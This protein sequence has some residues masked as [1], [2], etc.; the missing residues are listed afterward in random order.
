MKSLSQRAVEKERKFEEL[1]IDA[2]RRRERQDE[3][4]AWQEAQHSFQPDIGLTKHRQLSDKTPRDFYERLHRSGRAK[5]DRLARL[6]NRTSTHDPTTG[7]RLF[8][9]K[10]GRAP[11]FDR[12]AS[13]LSVHEFLF[14]S[15]HEYDDKRNLLRNYEEMRQEQLSSQSFVLSTSMSDGTI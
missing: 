15:R 5:A 4:V 6:R 14:A 1:Y 13:G 2:Q 12:N 11:N 10:V 8:Q 7:Q 3:Y 9:P